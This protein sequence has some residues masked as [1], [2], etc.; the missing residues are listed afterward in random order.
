MTSARPRCGIQSVLPFPSGRPKDRTLFSAHSN[1]KG[2][3]S[4]SGCV[5]IYDLGVY[6]E[7]LLAGLNPSATSPKKA[8]ATEG[9][10]DDFE[11]DERLN[12]PAAAK[13]KAATKDDAPPEL[14]PWFEHLKQFVDQGVRAF[15]LDGSAQVIEHPD[16]Q[17]G[18]GMTDEEMHN[19]YPVIYAKQMAR[20]FEN[21]TNRR[22]MVYSA[23]GYAGLQQFVATWAG[24]TGG[25]P[26]PLASM[27]NLGFSG[28]SNHSCDMDV[29]SAEGIHFGFLQTWAQQ[30]NWAYWRQPWLLEDAQ[31][32]AFR[33]YGQLRYKLLPYLYSTAAEATFTGYP[34]MRAMS[35]VY[36][37]DPAWD[38]NLGQYMLGEFLLVSAYSE[39]VRLPE[40]TWI[41]FWSGKQITGPANASRR[42][43]TLARWL[44][45]G[46]EWRHHSHLAGL[47]SCGER[48]VACR[49]ITRLSDRTQ[50][51]H[52]ARR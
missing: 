9:D 29:F 45:A 23:G 19:L 4:A 12:K 17:W 52:S 2:S 40:G 26:K 1:G 27:L 31:L 13:Q 21:Q 44:A 28:H 41:D 49:R 32:T 48:L 11:K 34:V 20:G 36:P 30:N 7:Q 10:P 22:S 47:R 14:E 38:T 18:N 15:K 8:S 51:L 39:E 5:A 42:N 25:G 37:E 6:E 24:D 46:E 3:S 35:M 16:R 43:D 50:H 33:E